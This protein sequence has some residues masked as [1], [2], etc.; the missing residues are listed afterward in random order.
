MD[1]PGDASTSSNGTE[2]A[3]RCCRLSGLIKCDGSVAAGPVWKYA[4]RVQFVCASLGALRSKSGFPDPVSLTFALTCPPSCPHPRRP[5]ALR[6]PVRLRRESGSS[7][8]AS[9]A[10][11]RCAPSCWPAPRRPACAAC[12]PASG[13][14]RQREVAAAPKAL[15][16][17][18]EG[19][20]CHRANRPDPRD[21]HEPSGQE[22]DGIAGMARKARASARAARSEP[23]PEA[24]RIRSRRSPCSPVEAS[25]LCSTAHKTDYVAPVV[26]LRPGARRRS[27]TRFAVSP[28]HNLSPAGRVA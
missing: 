19:L 4:D 15:H 28:Q 18:R 14:A 24:M 26:M 5:P 22:R 9:S 27:C 10:P 13:P 23:A 6:R 12:A 11:R 16:R 7:P 8:S 25:V 21:G 3:V 20:E 1:A 17:R 2:H